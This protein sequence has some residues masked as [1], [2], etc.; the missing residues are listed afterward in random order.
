MKVESLLIITF[1]AITATHAQDDRSFSLKEAQEYAVINSYSAQTAQMD[2]EKSKKRV[3]EITAIGL[4][5]VDANLSYQNY[6]RLPVTVIPADAFAV[7]GQ[8]APPAGELIPVTFGTDHNV[9]ADITANQL[10]FDGSYIV[11]LQAAKTYVE[12]AKNNQVK[13]EI[14]IKTAVAAAYYNVLAASRNF[15]ILEENLEKLETIYKETKAYYETGFLE[16]Q[17][18]EQIELTR[19]TLKSS[20]ENARRQVKITNNLLKFQMGIPIA[21]TITL[22]DK[23]DDLL[24]EG[25]NQEFLNT[26]FDVTNHIDYKIIATGIRANELT[27]KNEKY[28]YLPKLNGFVTHQQQSPSNDFNYF[29][30]ATWYPSTFWG[31]N[32]QVPIFSSF[33]RHNKVQQAKI[34]LDK[35]QIQK[36]QM[37]DNLKMNVDNARSN[38]AY[39]LDN[40]NLA[41]ENLELARR[42]VRKT[43]TKYKEGLSSSLDLAQTENQFLESQANYIRSLL[44]LLQS[45]I[46][47]DKAL[48]N[49]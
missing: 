34:E 42:I 14:E 4:P 35:S 44:N 37:E 26:S 5:Q 48:N 7:P 46:E 39:N 8:P 41:K 32:L 43:T 25:K 16:E 9:T 22:T 6:L 11:G 15:E 10:I 40:L 33:M 28:S 29:G 21:E 12:L 38:Y 36:T 27:L 31:L 45:K 19:M 1:L 24:A 17:D 49:Y 23:V 2:V 3:N 20:I 30:D 47:L 18:V 13:S